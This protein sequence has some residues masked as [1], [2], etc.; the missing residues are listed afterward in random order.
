MIKT[1]GRWPG[2]ELEREFDEFTIAIMKIRQD[3][4][5]QRPEDDSEDPQRFLMRHDQHGLLGL[6]AKPFDET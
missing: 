5:R 4:V 6:D 1:P 3:S 2:S